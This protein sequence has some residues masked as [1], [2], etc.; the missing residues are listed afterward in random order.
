MP[1]TFRRPVTF[2]QVIMLDELAVEKRPRWDSSNDKFQGTCREHNHK[3]PLTF[4]TEKELSML[5]NALDSGE[6]H[7]A[8]KVR[9]HIEFD[10]KLR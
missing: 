10:C 1:S 8:S 9:I 5:C 4:S 3:I 6:V 2:H 7:L